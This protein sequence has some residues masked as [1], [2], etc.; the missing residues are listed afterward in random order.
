MLNYKKLKKIL[1]S[2]TYGW[3]GNCYLITP[4]AGFCL[5]KCISETYNVIMLTE[6]LRLL[7]MKCTYIILVSY[8]HIIP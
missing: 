4:L 8:V 7:V 5:V 1:N 3:R 2:Y 6:F